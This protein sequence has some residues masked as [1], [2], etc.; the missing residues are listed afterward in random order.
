MSEPVRHPL[1]SRLLPQ[2][3]PGLQT[4]LLGLRGRPVELDASGVARLATPC[5]QVLIAAARSWREDGLG[6]ALATPSPEML[7][8]LARLEVDP[9]ALQSSEA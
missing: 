6:F 3:A 7:A 9:S 5:V 2:D 8:V 1:P 4:A